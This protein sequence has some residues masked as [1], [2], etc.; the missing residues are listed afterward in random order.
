MIIIRGIGTGPYVGVGKVKKIES[1]EDLQQLKG[2]EIVVLSHASRDMLSYLHRAG[3]VVTDYGGLTSHVAIVLREMKVPCVVGTGNGTQKLEEG[4][5]VTV[6]G[7]TGNIYEGFIEKEEKHDSAAFYYPATSIKVNLN[8]PEIALKVAPWADGVGSIRIENSIIRTGKHPHVLFEEGKLSKVIEDSV[9]LIADAFCPKPVWF[10]TFDI[11]T[12]ELK[13]LDGGN[14][15]PDEANP[16]MGLRGIHKDLQNPEIL[17]AEFEAISELIN[18]GYDN[19]GVKIPLVRDVSEYSEAKNIMR[20]LGI[21]PHRDL[22]VG[23]SIETPSAVFTL[24]DLIGV[25]MDFVTLGMSDMAMCALAVD[26]RGVKVAKHFD[27]THP[28]VLRMI[29][30]VIEKCNQQ[31]IESCICGHAG[32]DPA[33]VRWLVNSGISS[34]STNPDQILKIRKVVD[35]AEKTIISRGFTRHV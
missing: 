1:D 31:G 15:E 20:E 25:G 23:A 22:P 13:R 5:I 6:D 28:S 19:L 9:E 4:T 30:R 7:K 2:G 21:R 3:G 8:I 32:S 24:D 16:L 33:I 34:I 11:P 12:D 26:R 27:L 18:K 10:R 29:E 17:K 14:I 35:I